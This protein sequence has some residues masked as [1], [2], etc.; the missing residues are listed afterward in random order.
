MYIF[1]HREIPPVHFVQGSALGASLVGI[2][3]QFRLNSHKLEASISFIAT[4]PY[5]GF[6]LSNYLKKKDPS[7]ERLFVS[8]HIELVQGMFVLWSFHHGSQGKICECVVC[9]LYYYS[10]RGAQRQTG[11][12]WRIVFLSEQPIEKTAKT[13]IKIIQSFFAVWH[14]AQKVFDNF[15]ENNWIY[16]IMEH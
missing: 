5:P 13:C 8:A 7:F 9:S 12:F 14:N 11:H 10:I 4:S 1:Q 15:Y 6:N 16:L 3:E 2:L